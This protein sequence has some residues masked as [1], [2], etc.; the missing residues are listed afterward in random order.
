MSERVTYIEIDLK[1]CANV[2][3]SAPCT[4]AV[5]VTGERKCFNG[6]AT[7]QDR[8]NYS[9]ELETVRFNLASTLTDV[10]EIS[11]PNVKSVDYTPARLM[12]GESIGIRSSVSVTFADSRFPDTGPAGDRYL[13][14][15]NYDPYSLGTFWGKFRARFPYLRGHNL[16]LIQGTTSQTVSQMETRHFIID[17]MA[18][19]TSNGDFTIVA[20]DALKLTDSKRAQ[21]PVISN[22]FLSAALTSG[23]TSVTLNPVG[24]GDA[25]YPASLNTPLQD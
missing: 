6:L 23:A 9:E 3:G 13:S 22:G 25:E 4:A 1:R 17:S 20:K 16:R 14:D 19:P 7:C 18:G 2:Y 8:P 24:V 11:I 12:L 10:A 5:G 15:R 21:A